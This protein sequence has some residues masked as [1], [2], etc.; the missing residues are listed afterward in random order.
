M[1]AIRRGEASDLNAVA[2]IQQASAGAA[3]WSVAEYLEYAFLVAVLRGNVAGFL[4]S[5]DVAADEKEILNLAVAPE[6][7]R[8][9]VAKALL[10]SCLEG[11]SGVVILEVR[12]SNRIARS[13]Y[14][15]LGFQELGRRP[16]YYSSP[17]ESAIV[18]KFHSC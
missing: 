17:D 3:H 16:N 9:G 18:M 7:R 8:Q 5:R 12:E 11:F 13:F 6:F 15:K 14:Q 10:F 1:T 2:V 4:V